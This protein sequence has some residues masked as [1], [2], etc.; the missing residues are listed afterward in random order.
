MGALTTQGNV[1]S[2][3]TVGQAIKKNPGNTNT[4]G[5]SD[6]NVLAEVRLLAA[7]LTL[8]RQASICLWKHQQAC[9]F[10]TEQERMMI[11]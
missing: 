7:S 8:S 9:G 3:W 2:V 1:F 5:E 11:P 6:D 10:R 4:A